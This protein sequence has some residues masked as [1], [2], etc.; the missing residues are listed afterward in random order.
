M[1]D[2]KKILALLIMITVA[3]LAA[4]YTVF[5]EEK[6]EPALAVEFADGGA[7]TF[8]TQD[9]ELKIALRRQDVQ[10]EKVICFAEGNDGKEKWDISDIQWTSDREGSIFFRQQ[11]WYRVSV[12][13][14]DESYPVPE[15]CLETKAPKEPEINTGPYEQGTWTNRP[16]EIKLSGGSSFSGLSCYEYKESKKDQ[17]TTYKEDGIKV[18]TNGRHTYQ[19]RTV[20]RAGNR[21]KAVHV[22]V[23]FWREQAGRPNVSCA[24]A[25]KSGWYRKDVKIQV[26]ENKRLGPRLRTWIRIKDLTAGDSKTVEGNRLI[27]SEE[28]QY[29]VTVRQKDEAGNKSKSSWSHYIYLDKTQPDVTIEREQGQTYRRDGCRIKVSMKDQ[30]LDIDSIRWDT[31]GEIKNLKRKGNITTAD[32]CF[33]KEGRQ[34]LSVKCKDQAGN[35]AESFAEDFF[36]DRKSPSLKIQGVKPFGIYSFA[37]EPQVSCTDESPAEI[38]LLLNGK[39]V[40]TEKS[41]AG[42]QIK[43]SYQKLSED[44]YYCVEVRA[45]DSA[46]NKTS[47]KV[48]FT[49]SCKGTEIIPVQKTVRNNSTGEKESRYGFHIKNVVPSYVAEFS[50]NGRTVPYER[51]GDDLYVD[52]Q[53]LKNG[54]NQVKI[55]VK[56]LTG[57]VN[58]V[59]KPLVF[60][61]D[62]EPPVILVSGVRNGSIYKGKKEIQV[63][64]QNQNDRLTGLWI[65]EKEIP[66]AGG[67]AIVQCRAAGRHRLKAEAVGVSGSKSSKAVNFEIDTKASGISESTLQY[68]APGIYILTAFYLVFFFWRTRNS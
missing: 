68:I 32:V 56:D 21:S 33:S 2:R 27:L 20:S 40:K 51:K 30:F 5:A 63:K 12:V 57:H 45:R 60:S 62:A 10:R 47:E 29:K 31:T 42:E 61:Y 59:E 1:L 52:R 6:K 49:V 50:V 14:E 7:D 36:I 4:G 67:R 16:V 17:W 58:T 25:E 3:A 19:V 37:A 23:N 13:Y 15:F 46:G 66:V 41:Q 38:S 8:Y 11:G 44:G 53:Y 43:I 48:S 39:I 22:P 54:T 55:K 9:R 24:K 28:G 18:Q 34:R 65:D 26:K 64:V 35:C